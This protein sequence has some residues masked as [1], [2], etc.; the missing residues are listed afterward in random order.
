M[1]RSA[2]IASGLVLFILTLTVNLVARLVIA[3]S[4]ARRRASA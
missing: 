1:G 4:A 3:R 2:L